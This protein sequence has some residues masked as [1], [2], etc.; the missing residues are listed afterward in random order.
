[1]SEHIGLRGEAWFQAL[2]GRDRARKEDLASVLAV[3]ATIGD[4]LALFL[5]VIPNPESRLLEV[6][7]QGKA[8]TI[9]VRTL[10]GGI[11]RS[12]SRPVIWAPA[13]AL[14]LVS[15]GIHIPE[16]V[17]STLGLLGG[18][19]AGGA[20]LLTGSFFPRSPLL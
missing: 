18:A 2:T 1:M 5:C 13:L 11:V 15:I 10:A 9:G 7:S 16:C 8:T 12:L 19:A 4:E 3:D 17:A 6:D 14:V 20:L